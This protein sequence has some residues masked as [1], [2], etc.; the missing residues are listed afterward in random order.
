MSGEGYQQYCALA[1]A[2]DV[3]G[4][5]WT[6]LIVRELRPGPRRFTDLLDGLPGIS[7]NLLTDRLRDLERD[8]V[9]TR[10]EL[11]PPASRTVYALTE[12]GH[13]LA[14]AI[15]PLVEWG[16]K[17]LGK[18]R[19]GESFHPRWLG[20]AMASLADREAAQGVRETYQYIVGDHAFHFVI[21]D[22]TVEVH[23]G[24]S[25]APAVVVKS[26]ERTLGEIASGRTR[27]ST[28][29][30]A[31]AL[32]IT[33]ERHASRRLNKIFARVRRASASRR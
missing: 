31:G 2:L 13:D 1:R 24:V 20:V 18:R 3:I 29:L 27:A 22:S 12:D 4:N 26:D 17:R 15:A 32:T 21:D 11:P 10:K 33:G 28:A 9:I 30:A 7:R 16:A 23:D 14:K 6:L 25:E 5:R 8:G 19:S